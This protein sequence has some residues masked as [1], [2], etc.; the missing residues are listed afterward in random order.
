MERP[1]LHVLLSRAFHSVFF[2]SLHQ[3]DIC[4]GICDVLSLARKQQHT[5]RVW[6]LCDKTFCVVTWR[7]C[8]RCWPVCS[9]A[10]RLACPAET[11]LS[12]SCSLSVRAK[13]IV[14]FG[15]PSWTVHDSLESSLCSSQHCSCGLAKPEADDTTKHAVWPAAKL[16]IIYADASLP[17]M[18][19][20]DPCC[21]AHTCPP[22]QAWSGTRWVHSQC[23]RTGYVLH[24]GRQGCPMLCALALFAH[25]IRALRVWLAQA[26]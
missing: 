17:G 11:M 13:C 20:Y 3:D 26:A 12:D 8:D 6:G 7:L 2:L 5:V 23:C 24:G 1:R 22:H 14:V 21:H 25:K 18:S 16:M 15:Y 9:R 4:H 19:P 10:G